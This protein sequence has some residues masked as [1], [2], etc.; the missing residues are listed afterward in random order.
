MEKC[1]ARS[2]KGRLA[3]Q[4]LRLGNEDLAAA[5]APDIASQL[6][7]HVAA[8]SDDELQTE[9]AES[10]HWCCCQHDPQFPAVLGQTPGAPW[11]LF[12]SGDPLRL[13]RLHPKGAVAIVGSRRA[14]TYG[15]ELART[16]GRD[17]AGAGL[18]VISGLAFGI[19]SCAHR[20]ALEA[21]TTAAVLG[22]GVDVP[23]PASHR[24]LWRRICEEGLVISELPLGSTPWRWTFPA[25]NRIV[26]ALAA[27]T[28]VVEAAERS[29][30][31]VTADLA[32][33]LGRDIGAV[34]GPVNS[35]GSA[36]TNALLSKGACLIRDAQ[37][38]LDAMLGP[39]V[40]R[41]GPAGPQPGRTQREV[42][43]ALKDGA[44][45]LEE[46]VG[47]TDLPR[48][49]ARRGLDSLAALGYVE[50]HSTFRYRPSGLEPPLA[51]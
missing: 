3:T 10:S 40:K 27:M 37:D 38:V 5:V 9:I 7:E 45:S 32:A 42:L 50:V 36:G 25:R 2:A 16:L 29:G 12:G 35:R 30:S 26:A 51:H 48:E 8:V 1:L 49:E 13:A 21:G 4:L 46:I 19:D 18:A 33:D 23:Y 31:L 47:D 43:A 44:Q 24:S 6:L 22:C 15:R 11:A 28:I 34:P 20:G 39:G 17:L 41:A 14:D